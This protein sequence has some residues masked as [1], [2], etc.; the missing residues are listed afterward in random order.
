MTVQMSDLDNILKKV[1]G[2]RKKKKRL[3]LAI[4]YL[5]KSGN[6]KYGRKRTT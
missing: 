3:K 5:N 4:N 1:V 2:G 6:M